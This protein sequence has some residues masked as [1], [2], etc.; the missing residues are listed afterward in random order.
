MSDLF[1]QVSL[2]SLVSW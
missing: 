1:A 2:A